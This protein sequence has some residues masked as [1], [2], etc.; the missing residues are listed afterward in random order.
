MRLLLNFVSLEKNKVNNIYLVFIYIYY[1]AFTFSVVH[2][3]ILFIN[4]LYPVTILSIHQLNDK[5]KG[6]LDF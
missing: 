3:S 4:E 2:V 5:N 6:I 1:C